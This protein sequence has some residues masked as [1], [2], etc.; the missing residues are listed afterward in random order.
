MNDLIQIQNLS[1]TY[2]KHQVLSGVSLSIPPC[3]ILFVMGNNGSGKTTLIK[4]MLNRQTPTSGTISYQGNELSRIG[5]TRLARLVSYVPQ[6][7][8]VGC[9]YKVKDYLVLGRNPYIAFASPQK[10]DYELAA[11]YAE[12]T[13]IKSV[14]E[15]PFYTLSGGQKQWA[16][17]TRALVQETPII[18]MDEP[19]SALDM[20]KQAELLCLLRDLRNQDEK[21]IILTSH[22]PNH[23]TALDCNVCVLHRERVYAYGPPRQVLRP[24]MIS[25]IYGDHIELF[26]N[27][28]IGFSLSTE[29]GFV[30]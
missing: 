9:D 3:S 7:I 5:R 4:C 19:M 10:R 6:N 16:V 23:C 29:S 28:Y 21:T 22:N 25:E 14:W 12:K 17:I 11:F 26:E 1:C 27:G 20:G 30:L 18:I 24:D 2:G 15:K 8:H 13:G